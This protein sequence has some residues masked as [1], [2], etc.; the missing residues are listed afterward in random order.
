[1]FRYSIF[2]TALILVGSVAA[3]S[4][5]QINSQGNYLMN[6]ST[7]PAAEQRAR[8]TSGLSMWV[9]PTALGFSSAPVTR[10]DS[11]GNYWMDRS[12]GAE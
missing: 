11:E 12:K 3:A 5:A 4:A 9:D 6:R 10:I 2:A 1:M 8:Q 7:G